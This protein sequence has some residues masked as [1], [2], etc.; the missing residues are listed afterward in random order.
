MDHPS[1]WQPSPL[2]PDPPPIP[3]PPGP[4]PHR[5][6]LRLLV[7]S[8]IVA[9]ILATAASLTPRHL[10]SWDVAWLTPT[11]V[12][13]LLMVSR[14]AATRLA[15]GQ[16]ARQMLAVVAFG[17][18][19][20]V[21][22]SYRN[23]L[24]GVFD[25]ALGAIVPSRGIQVGQG[26]MQFTADDSGQF[27][28]DAKVD[29]VGVHFLVDTGASGMT[30]SKEDARRLG[31]DLKDLRFTGQFSTANGATRAAPVTL[32]SIEIGP[33]TANNVRAWVNEGELNQSLLGMS[34]L[35]TLGR[36]DIQGDRMTIER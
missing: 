24:G 35:S 20:M 9:A 21:G 23:D 10:D 33:L 1:P 31:Y 12:V 26:R 25:R 27:F 29:G 11:A 36:I 4:P 8:G 3:P 32:D 34:Y 13:A 17:V 7:I 16:M 14:L 22:Y 6:W 28:I 19:L 18:V 15:L 5:P 2:P 30:L